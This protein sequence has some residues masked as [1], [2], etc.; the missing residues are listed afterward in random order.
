ME[1]L[2]VGSDATKDRVNGSM[3]DRE[4]LETLVATMKERERR[5]MELLNTSAPERIEHD[6]RN[7]LNELV[8]LRALFNPQRHT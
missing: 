3:S 2:S 8:I 6:L 7:V 1:S 5:L 4:S